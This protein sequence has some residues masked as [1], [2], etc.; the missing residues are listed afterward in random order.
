M[1]SL[2]SFVF[3]GTMHFLAALITDFVW[4]SLHI[5]IH[6]IGHVL[7][8]LMV[9]SRITQVGINK[10]GIFVG[11]TSARTPLRN[12]MVAMAGPGINILTWIVFVIYGLPHAWIPLVIGLINLMS[13]P[14]SDFTNSRSY[15]RGF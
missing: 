8:A 2:Q 5:V 15:I 9:G 13:I 7:A 6:E 14:N 1:I 3:Y 12:V 11:R 4:G 10:S